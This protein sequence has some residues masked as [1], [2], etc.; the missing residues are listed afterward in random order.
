VRL[1]PAAIAIR[2]AEAALAGGLAAAVSAATFALMSWA[3]TPAQAASPKPPAPFSQ[4]SQALTASPRSLTH[5]L[6]APPAQHQHQ[7]RSCSPHAALTAALATVLRDQTGSLAVGVT[8]LSTG[9]TASYHPRE[10]F[11][12]ASIVKADILATALL[13]AQRQHAGLSPAEQ[14][15]ATAMI[16]ESDNDAASA[17]WNTIGAAPGLAAADR[18]LGLRYTE[19]GPGGLWGLTATTVTDQLRLLAALTSRHSPLTAA[20]RHYE[21]TLMRS[22]AD[23]QNWG[24][25]AA[26]DPGTRPGVKNGWLP[27]GP[28]GLWVINS[29][30]VLRHDGQRLL[31]AVLSSGQ[32]TQAAGISQVQAA[33]RAAAAS[34]TQPACPARAG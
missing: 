6:A 15:L 32:P 19:P 12:T 11:H 4:A 29:I 1:R 23:G 9:V 16:E 26:A 20:A 30:G 24:V 10:L 3:E 22:V 13:Q 7:P 14:Q 33:A 34:V 25:T 31:V 21:L 27:D 8:D 18:V 28:S 17:L 2:C 5:S